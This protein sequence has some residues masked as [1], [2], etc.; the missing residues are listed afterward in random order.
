M[1]G[2][3]TEKK[4]LYYLDKCKPATYHAVQTPSPASWHQRLGHPSH[5][6]LRFLPNF[7]GLIKPCDASDCLVCPLEK[8]TRTPFSLSSISTVKPFELLHIDI[9]GAYHIPSFSGARYFLTI[10]DDY[11]HCTW[12]Y[13]MCHKSDTRTFFMHFITLVET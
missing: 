6:V 13:L 9:W 4:G 11:T 2:T 8:Q 3:R 5:K 7:V 12:V 10:V 1:I